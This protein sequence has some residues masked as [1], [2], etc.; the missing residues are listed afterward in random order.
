DLC[1]FATRR[2]GTPRSSTVTLVVHLAHCFDCTVSSVLK[3]PTIEHSETSNDE[4]SNKDSMA[5]GRPRGRRGMRWDRLVTRAQPEIYNEE[6]GDK[7]AMFQKQI[8]SV[9][10]EEGR[11]EG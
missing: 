10:Q 4:M 1:N 6:G 9:W 8:G 5:R 7:L 3:V 2:N 11:R